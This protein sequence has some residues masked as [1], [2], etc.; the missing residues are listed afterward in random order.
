[1]R[2]L[3]AV[4]PALITVLAITSPTFA[5]SRRAELRGAWIG[6]GYDRDWPAIMR[7]LKENG[8]S[9]L[10]PNFS[11]GA[12]AYYPSQVLPP[13]DPSRTDD[14]LADAAAA[15]R[16]HGIEL[17]VWR[18]NWALY[19]ATPE[20]IADLEQA[21]RLQR[22]SR[23]EL[24][25][26]DPAVRVDW[27]CPSH[28]ENRELEKGAM[29]E[30]VREYDI[31]GIQFGDMRFPGE[32]Y[33]FC[34]G[35]KERFQQQTGAQVE[36][37]PA[38]VLSGDL[39]GRWRNW[40][41][42]LLTSLV[43][44]TAEAASAVKPDIHVSLAAWPYLEAGRET[45][46]QDAAAW[47]RSG[48][49]DFVCPMDYTLDRDEL[50]R[51]LDEQ[52]DAVR[53]AV[54]VYAGLGAFKMK[55]L[56]TLI[57]QVEAAR[58]AG[59]DGFVAFAYDSGKLAH[60]LPDLRA[61]V[62]AADPR[63]SPHRHPPARLAFAGEAASPPALGR[64]V[65]AG[66]KLEIEIILGWEPPTLD[67]E[68]AG[69][70]EAGAMLERALDIRNPSETYDG[71]RHI[72]DVA[73]EEDRLSGRIVVEGPEG[74]SRIMLGGFDSAYRFD[75]KLGFS[76]PEGRFRVAIYGA[77]RNPQGSYDFVI[78]SPVLVGT[79]KE[80]LAVGELHA[81]LSRLQ[82]DGCDRPEAD[83]LRALSPIS[84]QFR[85]TGPG[86]GEWWLRFVDGDCEVGA[87]LIDDPDLTFVAS[88]GDFAALARGEMDPRALWERGRL[89]IIGD[90]E[91]LGR[92]TD[93]YAETL[94]PT[95]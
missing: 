40:R 52:I 22:S 25:R 26:D 23:G 36:Q 44:E 79:P 68:L 72:P 81:E 27:L 66:A 59:A 28:P 5:Q 7:S 74:N 35:C 95:G 63:P 87:G 10:F 6:S 60:W 62:A 39:S 49:I 11:T 33:C 38:D 43:E 34:E 46:A 64:T 80:E 58:T 78:R 90:D 51:L 13:R 69:A 75:R 1:M 65:I 92:L 19:G 91:T 93:A 85:A 48:V 83:V 67:D 45:Y 88:T 2:K 21:G 76:A 30:L 57:E 12:V 61:T 9:A 41:R 94:E 15:A 24:A 82:Q 37:W 16:E 84:V 18:I 89:E 14:E 42:G 4:L 77:V 70:A 8:F 17:H 56:L 53:G 86:G 54:P 20:Q 32:A 3:R 47:A 29:V 71:Q 73:V 31:A 55:S 50:A